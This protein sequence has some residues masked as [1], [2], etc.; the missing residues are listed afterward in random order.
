MS[1]LDFAIEKHME[2]LVK[3]LKRPFCVRDFDH[4]EYDGIA[5]RVDS[6]TF[7]NKICQLKKSA[8]VILQYKT[9]YA[10]YSL[11]GYDFRKTN[12]I[13]HDHAGLPIKEGARAQTPLYINLKQKSQEKQSLHDIRLTFDAPEIWKYY[14]QK[15]NNLINPSNKD[16]RLDPW[17]FMDEIDVSVTVHHTD[18]VSVSISCSSRP[19]VI[20]VPDLFYLVEILT[21]TE[22]R[23][24]EY[25]NEKIS[26]ELSLNIPRFSKWV[27]KMWHFGVDSIDRYEGQ[28][29]H[30]TV[31][32]GMSEL[33]RTYTKRL[34]DG[35]VHVRK[36]LQEIPDKPILQAILDKVYSG[37]KLID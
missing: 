2:H 33:Y 27:V 20:D 31:E 32:K 23:I 12:S 34:N 6:G 30:I 1:K 28:D 25:W 36:E 15:F 5:Y 4:F 35:Q 24:K 21:R 18:K 19:I 29:F 9:T 14:S 37:G 11:P 13:T 7:R 22:L 26:P 16:I 8:M 17:Q 3:D 10:Y